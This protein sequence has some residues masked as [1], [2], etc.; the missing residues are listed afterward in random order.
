MRISR[1]LADEPTLFLLRK[2]WRFSEGRRHKIVLYSVMLVLANLAVLIP[3]ALFG[4]FIR[5]V[6]IHGITEASLPRLLLLLGG[7]FANVF[8]FWGLHGPARVIERQVAFAAEMSYRRYL[9]GCVL[10]LGLTWH[11]EHDSGD[12]IDKVNKAGDGIT[13]FGQNVFQVIQVVVKLVGTATA[14]CWFS[15]WV[16]GLAFALVLVSFV[17]I[18]QFDKRLMLQYRGLNKFSNQASAKVFDALSNVTTAKILHIEGPLLEGVMARYTAPLQLFRANAI[19][20]ELKW[21]AG[22]VCFQGV[23]ILPLVVFVLRAVARDEAVDAG[24]VSTL[25]MYLVSL[26]SV[27][28]GFSAFYQE[29]NMHK[30]RVLNAAPIEVAYAE[31]QLLNRRP[32]E[33]WQ[34][35]AVQDLVFSYE[36]TSAKS[37]LRGVQMQLRRGERIALVGESGAGKSTFLKV[38]HGMYT[39]AH[40]GLGVDGAPAAPTCF[41]DVDLRTMLVPQEPE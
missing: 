13:G 21:F 14:V 40:G 5:E 16:G 17:A 23:A 24:T 22:A 19:L 1:L 6:Q 3:P 25:Y 10:E 18:F 30:H 8:V 32:V 37:N 34:E 4:L 9:L 38:L 27:Y 31:A 41:A 7:L 15:P 29:I 35:L 33:A 36:G 12:T 11:G 26:T 39:N 20:N 28:S 2:L